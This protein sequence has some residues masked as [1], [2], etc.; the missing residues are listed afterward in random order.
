ME[1][2]RLIWKPIK[3]GNAHPTEFKINDEK[4]SGKYL[5]NIFR[6]E[7]VKGRQY[8]NSGRRGRQRSF[9]KAPLFFPAPQL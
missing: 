4:E 9:E 2:Y 5:F 8:H 1:P 6:Q 3:K 7:S